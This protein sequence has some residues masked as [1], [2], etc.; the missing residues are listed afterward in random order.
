MFML[1]GK[2]QDVL[3]TDLMEKRACIQQKSTEQLLVAPLA[4]KAISPSELSEIIHNYW[5]TGTN[6]DDLTFTKS[7]LPT[8]CNILQTRG[9]PPGWPTEQ[10]FAQMMQPLYDHVSKTKR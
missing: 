6:L 1:R 5:Q 10:S 3:L 8:A 4:V 2:S 7:P 9:N